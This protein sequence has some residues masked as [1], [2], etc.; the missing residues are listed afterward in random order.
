M[1]PRTLAPYVLRTI[2]RH[3]LNGHCITLQTLVEDINVRRGDLRKTVSALHR[4]GLVDAL[5]MRLTLR[6][7]TIG[8]SLLRV[9][10]P[11]LR[12]EVVASVAA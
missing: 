3:Q 10:L 2:A 11:P 5:T 1:N 4:E 12:E 6:G 9:D 8:V 7:F